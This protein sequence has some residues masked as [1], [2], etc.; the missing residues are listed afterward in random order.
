MLLIWLEVF[1][2]SLWWIQPTSLR[3]PPPVSSCCQCSQLSLC[4][5][6]QF[7]YFSIRGNTH[8]PYTYAPMQYVWSH[9]V[10]LTMHIF[11]S[12]FF[13]PPFSSDVPCTMSLTEMKSLFR[14]DDIIASATQPITTLEIS[15]R[16]GQGLHEVLIWL[17]S[18][19]V[20][21]SSLY[22]FLK[23]HKACLHTI[24]KRVYL[25]AKLGSVEKM[26]RHM[27]KETCCYLN[28]YIKYSDALSGQKK[29]VM[30]WWYQQNGVVLR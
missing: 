24:N 29:K 15:A 11:L 8:L 6:P 30:H 21:W 18:I 5:V 28:H 13:S 23:K 9:S 3:C 27:T 19:M 12:L 22:L 14:M 2:H 16:T 10:I 20:K 17:E 1:F 25:C 4:T 26:E 7:L